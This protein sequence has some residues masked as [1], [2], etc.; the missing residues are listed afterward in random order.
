MALRK[1]GDGMLRFA[2]IQSL[3]DVAA[4]QWDALNPPSL[5]S[6]AFLSALEDSQAV[7]RARG[8]QA[9]HLLAFAQDRLVGALPL[10]IKYHSMGE[11]VFDFAFMRAYAAQQLAYYPKLLAM[12]PFTP[13]TTPRLLTHPAQPR[14]LLIPA[15]LQ[16]LG[17]TAQDYS[18]M[19]ALFLPEADVPDW[20]QR[21]Y[22]TRIDCQFHW[23]N[24][25][26]RDFDDY[27]ESFSS[28]KRKKAKRERRRVLEMGIELEWR[29][30]DALSESEWQRVY[31][32]KRQ[33]FLR[34][35][36]EPY[37]PLQFFTQLR[38]TCPDVVW[39]NLA[40]H[41]QEIVAAAIFFKSHDTLYGR[42]WGAI[43]AIHSLHFE[44]CYHQGIEFCLTH[45]LTRFEPGTQ[46]EHKIARGFSPTLTQSVHRFNHPGFQAAAVDYFAAERANVQLYMQ[47]ANELKPFKRQH[48][49]ESQAW[50]DAT[51]EPL[52]LTPLDVT[53]PA[54]TERAP[55]KPDPNQ[56]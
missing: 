46:G 51:S 40:K 34:H 13:A 16:T 21:G 41:G 29:R 24:R 54:V 48:S 10:Y 32:L 1:E 43:D 23:H 55:S 5:L 35:G 2:Y 33:T 11:F 38:A 50:Q 44:V 53:A 31:A 37:L 30:A 42:Y 49:Q 25:G 45:G 26:Y 4:D 15:L 17:Q 20:T 8:W 28:D 19:H 14:E 6:H 3:Q 12:V 9:Q 27:L 39:V 36:H 22:L 56:A 7:Q 18:S 47:Q 52:S